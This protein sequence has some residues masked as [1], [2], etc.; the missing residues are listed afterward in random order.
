MA[1]SKEFDK[2][3]AVAAA[4]DVFREHGFEGTSTEMLVRAMKIGRQSL[5]DTFGDKWAL[6]RLAVERYVFEETEAHAAMLRSKPR[7]IDGIAAMIEQVVERAHLACLGVNSICEF[8]QSRP[9]L[10]ALHRA[11]DNRLR[12]AT[13]ECI[14]QAQVESEVEN[15][16]PAEAVAG[17][18]IASIAGIRIAARG[19]AARQELESLGRLALR[20]IR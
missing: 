19:G 1:R 11:A 7:A 17:F 4:I 3:K 12:K 9:E 13:M 2:D 15:S 5:Y 6:Y 20:A 8:G 16:L 10:N 18:L 14:K